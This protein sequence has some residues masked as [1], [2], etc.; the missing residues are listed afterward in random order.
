MASSL[1]D[2][3]QK[4]FSNPHSAIKPRFLSLIEGEQARWILFAP[5][6]LGLGIA[7]WFLLPFVA[8]RQAALGMA[9]VVALSG[10]LLRGLSARIIIAGGLLVAL[11]IGAAELRSLSVAAPVLHH[12]LGDATLT[13]N[14]L[15]VE[16]RSGGDRWRLLLLRDA[17]DIDP[18]V[19]IRVTLAGK[20]PPGIEPGA[21]IAVSAILQ[22]RAGPVFP[23][24][25]DM[26]RV[27]WFEGISASGRA[28]ASPMLLA[29][30][31]PGR[32]WLARQRAHL[33]A[34]LQARIGGDA[35]RVAAALVTGDQ[36]QVPAP[37][38]DSMRI[39]GLAHL[40][41]VSGFHIAVVAGGSLLL[42]RKLL[43]LWPWFALRV[44]VRAV[45]AILA[46]LTVTAY[47]LLAGAEV[48]AVRAAIAAWIILVAL[49]CGR[50][51]LSMRL[52]AFAAFAIL[53]LRPEALLSPSF[54]LS[55]AAVTAL[56][57]LSESA[58]GQ[59]HLKPDPDAGL[60]QKFGR[61]ALAL[62]LSGIVAELILSPIAMAHFGRA[63]LYG[64]I[65]NIIAIPLTSLA[66]MPLL[67]AFL[68]SA[69]VGL[70]GIFAPVAAWTLDLL[71]GL[72]GRVSAWPGASVSVPSV[73]TPAFALGV[74]GAILLGLFSQRLRW[75]GAPLLAAGLA[76]ALFSP[77]PD[78]FVAAD[79]RQVALVADGAIHFLRPQRGGFTARAWAEAAD[80]PSGG[81]FE[82][83]PGSRCSEGG[84]ALAVNGVRVLALKTEP[85]GPVAALCA[86]FDIVVAPTG[87][88]DCHPGW[89]LLDAPAL[90]KSGAVALFTTNRDMQSTAQGTG[91][92][93]WSPSA[94][95]GEQQTLL[96]TTRWIPPLTE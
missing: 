87:L 68:L 53:L 74:A 81:L 42:F 38:L 65:A 15:A 86:A 78:V 51:P 48:P 32:L 84:C 47:A 23:G 46:G 92:H 16:A 91:D 33:T 1:S 55:F 45:A 93:P 40:L 72:S 27:A 37:I 4:A 34:F 57:L 50:N 82:Q 89:L 76:L 17:S 13:G 58:F 80:V 12:R 21:R 29:P 83:M 64:V 54:Q 9:L 5:V 31:P 56:V 11:G 30:A 59:R 96:G 70:E 77:R 22:P 20:P 39:S 95:P 63:G 2:A 79:G 94:L 35:G 28:T 69:F 44:S 49:A 3:P 24:G 10:L 41:S 88:T 52:I 62:I 18:A 43:A 6:A 90:R 73:P 61:Y 14:V 8:Q 71:I 66:I 7:L 85:G 67:A 36:G 25:Y 19:K 75:L 26:A 60:L